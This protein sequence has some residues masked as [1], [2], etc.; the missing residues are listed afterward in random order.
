MQE[1]RDFWSL[2]LT[3]TG[4][5]TSQLRGRW[6]HTGKGH[7]C[8]WWRATRQCRCWPS[9]EELGSNRCRGV[10]SVTEVLHGLL[11][12]GRLVLVV[13]PDVVDGLEDGLADGVVV[14]ADKVTGVRR[15]SR[16]RCGDIGHLLLELP[17][18]VELGVRDVEDAGDV[19]RV[20]KHRLQA[21]HDDH[22]DPLPWSEGA[23]RERWFWLTFAKLGPKAFVVFLLLRLAG[24]VLSFSFY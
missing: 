1:K 3:R 23:R 4:C 7:G 14:K 6:L 15:A 11:G 24:R 9:R 22:H 5:E 8:Q 10:K 19:D 13:L 12:D 16:A 20:T 17:E 2:C 21:L 18:L